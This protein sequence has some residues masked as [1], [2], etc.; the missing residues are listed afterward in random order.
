MRNR[1]RS[2]A[3]VS[4]MIRGHLGDIYSQVHKVTDSPESEWFFWTG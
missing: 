4:G 1:R 2:G 3:E